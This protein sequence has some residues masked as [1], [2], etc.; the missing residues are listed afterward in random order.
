MRILGIDPGTAITGFG[1]L[2]TLGNRFKLLD[3]GTSDC[4][5]YLAPAKIGK[6]IRG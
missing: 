3:Y 4:I 6:Y 2:E 1:V 5:R